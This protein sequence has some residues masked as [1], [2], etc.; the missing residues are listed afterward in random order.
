M[1][2]LDAFEDRFGSGNQEPG[3]AHSRSETIA[4]VRG[5]QSEADALAEMA[6]GGVDPVRQDALVF[7]SRVLGQVIHQLVT[8]E[9]TRLKMRPDGCGVT[10]K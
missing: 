7:V 10:Y 4:Y 8:G 2:N 9:T 6:S 1:S 5:L 3:I